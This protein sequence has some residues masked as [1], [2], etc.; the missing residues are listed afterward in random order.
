MEAIKKLVNEYVSINNEIRNLNQGG[1]GIFAEHLYFTLKKMGYKPRLILLTRDKEQLRKFVKLN[2]TDCSDFYFLSIGHV[3]VSINGKLIDSRGI[4]DTVEE[5][6]SSLYYEY[7]TLPVKL[8]LLQ[9][10]N[11]D[12]HFWN[13]SFDRRN[14]KTIE[15]KL[16]NCYKKLHKKL[17]VSI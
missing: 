13:S 10:W 11:K 1:C 3:V 12:E 4:H 7:K 17:E 16:A 2:T 9:K 14:I 15:K 8:A 6:W 5:C